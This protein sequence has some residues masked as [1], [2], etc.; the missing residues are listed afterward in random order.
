M[1]K[2]KHFSFRCTDEDWEYI[3]NIAELDDRTPSYVLIQMIR[4]F[5][6]HKIK[7]INEVRIIR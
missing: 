5:K 4:K 1:K 7:K 3:S 2:D 6:E